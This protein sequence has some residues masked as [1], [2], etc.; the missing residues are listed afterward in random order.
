VTEDRD[1]GPPSRSRPRWSAAVLSFIAFFF[2][3]GA[4]TVWRSTP[5]VARAQPIA[6]NH[7]KHVEEL[8]LACSTC[9]QFYEKEAF[10]GLPGADTCSS[11]HQEPVG[12]SKE[13]AKLVR[14]LQS[15]APLEWTP[16]FRQPA[17]IFYSHRRHVVAAKIQCAVCHGSIGASTAPPQ[18]VRRLRMQDCLDCH[19]RSG[20]TTDCTGC[21]R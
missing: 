2:L 12:K 7:K 8:E 5:R 20:V 11:C 3:T 14:L 6:F 17:H 1:P 16:L 15:G 13:E 21:H 4:I 18:S 10:S 19:R 9:H